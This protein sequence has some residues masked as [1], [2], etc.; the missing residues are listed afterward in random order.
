MVNHAELLNKYFPDLAGEA[1]EKLLQLPAI[2]GEWNAKINVVSRKDMD[3]FFEHH[4]IHSLALT[5]FVKLQPGW[6]I[7]DVGTG[8]GFPGIPLA[9]CYPE[10]QFILS[11]SI[12]KKIKVVQEVAAS[13]ALSNI[14]ARALRA[15]QIQGPFDLVVSRAVTRLAGFYPW[16]KGKIRQNGVDGRGM[17]F[18]KGG[19][20]DEEIREFLTSY[21]KCHIQE[22]SIFEQIDRPFFETKKVLLLT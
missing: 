15:E 12:A 14:D 6:R 19:D 3:D 10:A 1:V 17:A 4:V 9:I 21:P 22:K 20:L 2:Y 16:V 18:L 11:D 5:R 7:L 13:L 8:G